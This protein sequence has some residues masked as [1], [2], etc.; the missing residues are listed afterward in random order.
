MA[1]NGRFA[2]TWT[3]QGGDIGRSPDLGSDDYRGVMARFY[4]AD[5]APLG[6]QSNVNTFLR[7]AQEGP[8][9]SA[10]PTGGFLL[11]WMSLAVQDGDGSG[12]YSRTF[13]PAGHPRGGEVRVNVHVAGSQS[14][15]AVAVAPNGKGVV[16]W[17]GPDGAESGISARLL[18]PRPGS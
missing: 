3:D 7:G 14:Y 15:P 9:V 6:P 11:V 16:A 5:G 18:R 17:T 12:I 8:V 1:P 10:L 13:G 2:V 4:T